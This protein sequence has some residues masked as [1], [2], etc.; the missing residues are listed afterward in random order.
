MRRKKKTAGEFKREERKK[1]YD[2]HPEEKGKC[3][4]PSQGKRER[5]GTR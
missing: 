5:G 3:V 2:Y 1:A 4:S